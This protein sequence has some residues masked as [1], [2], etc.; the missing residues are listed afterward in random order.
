MAYFDVYSHYFRFNNPLDTSS[1][2]YNSELRS[3]QIHEERNSPRSGT[4]MFFSKKKSE[5]PKIGKM[6]THE[7]NS[8]CDVSC[9]GSSTPSRKSKNDIRDIDSA[10]Q[11]PSVV[12]YRIT[13]TCTVYLRCII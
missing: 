1:S 4:S 2:H 5:R 12:C 3:V 8:S 7:V 10:Y 11:E 13:N 9:E 6:N